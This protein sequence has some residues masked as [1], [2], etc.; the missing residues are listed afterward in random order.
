MTAEQVGLKGA[1]VLCAL[2]PL[3]GI[4]LVTMMMKKLKTE[5]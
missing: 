3:L 5:V 1:M 4:V 2:F